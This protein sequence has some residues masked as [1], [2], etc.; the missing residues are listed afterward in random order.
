MSTELIQDQLCFS[1]GD[2][3]WFTE[4]DEVG[5]LALVAGVTHQPTLPGTCR[6]GCGSGT[7]SDQVTVTFTSPLSGITQIAQTTT[8]RLRQ[9]SEPLTPQQQEIV[10]KLTNDLLNW[11]IRERDR[12]DR[13]A[14][15]T[16]RRADAAEATINLMRAYAIDKS[17]DGT[18][19]RGGLNEFLQAHDLPTYAPRYEA[20]VALT[21]RVTVD[22]DDDEDEDDL[23]RIIESNLAI[24]TDDSD[25]LRI[26]DWSV[27][28]D[29]VSHVEE[30]TD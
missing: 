15:E 24:D 16:S 12:A 6:C 8:M 27:D 19:C 20:R 11:C 4:A 9:A 29:A 26:D 7:P 22:C 10:R 28:Y 17:R 5:R 1:V 3:V 21:L 30:V 25:R 14:E 2:V 18:I 13:L 23:Q